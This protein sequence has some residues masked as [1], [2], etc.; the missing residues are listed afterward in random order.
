MVQRKERSR[1]ERERWKGLV[2]EKWGAVMKVLSSGGIVE[3]S[4]RGM[5]VCC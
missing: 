3:G 4:S 5:I 1:E 2:D